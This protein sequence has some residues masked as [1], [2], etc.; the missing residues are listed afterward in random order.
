[1]VL[2]RG[3]SIAVAGRPEPSGKFD[4][5]VVADQSGFFLVPRS[6]WAWM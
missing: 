5:F 1:V 6:R 3:D 4:R 2:R